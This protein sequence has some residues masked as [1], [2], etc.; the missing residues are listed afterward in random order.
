M[1]IGPQNLDRMATIYGPATWDVYA[2]LDES[3]DPRGPDMLYD[4]AADHITEHATVLDAGCRDATHLI[5]L[6]RRHPGITGIGVEPVAIHVERAVAAVQAANLDDRLTIHHGVMHDVP[7]SDHSVDFVW[8]RDVLVQVDDVVGG[9]RGLRRVMSPDARLL[10]YNAF[11]TNRLDGG[12]L[13]MM[14]R[15]LGWLE[16]NVRRDQMEAAFAAVGFA[17]ERVVE[18]GTEWREYAE[19]RTQPA[20]RALLRLA[21]LR[22][23]RAHIVSWRGQEIYDH[24]EANLHYEV[25]LFVGKLE[26][27]VHVLAKAPPR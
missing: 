21:R 10:S 22:R 17:I 2:R 16:D 24:I 25:F 23:Q 4:L 26:P 1:G 3:L 12:D 19:E 13:A 15:H 27:V 20:S 9:L 8:C 11:A 14:R 6:A 18:V 5:E 7:I